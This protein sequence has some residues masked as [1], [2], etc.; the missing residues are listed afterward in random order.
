[1]DKKL[2]GPGISLVS[3]SLLAGLLELEPKSGQVQKGYLNYANLT[4]NDG[5]RAL[6]IL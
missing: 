4:T 1:M 6:A 2:K 5:S 3:P